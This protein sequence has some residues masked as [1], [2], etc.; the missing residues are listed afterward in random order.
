MVA[1]PAALLGHL[2][3]FLAVLP[4]VLGTVFV[5]ALRSTLT[6][7]TSTAYS[8]FPSS[9]VTRP[10]STDTCQGGQSC[11]V[12][13]IDNGVA[14]LL[15][16]F[17]ACFVGLYNGNGVSCPARSS[18]VVGEMLSPDVLGIVL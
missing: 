8:R 7:Q 9:Q 14:P 5:S 4:T 16:D 17:G 2:C 6:E 12:E 13:W 15:S 11:L 3:V 18:F 1:F 10:L